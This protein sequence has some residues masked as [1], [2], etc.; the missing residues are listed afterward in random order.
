MLVHDF[1]TRIARFPKTP[2]PLKKKNHIK[3]I[4]RKKQLLRRLEVG[5]PH[6][7]THIHPLPESS[8]LAIVLEGKV[9][10]E[11]AKPINHLG[12]FLALTGHQMDQ[13]P[14]IPWKTA[15]HRDIKKKDRNAERDI[16][17]SQTCKSSKCTQPIQR[18]HFFVWLHELFSTAR[19]FWGSI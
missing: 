17:L 1:R 10:V 16:A 7:R 15:R 19:F 13:N 14:Y 2:T 3:I 18:R 4:K 9:V 8:F 6:P 11:N 12:R 5:S